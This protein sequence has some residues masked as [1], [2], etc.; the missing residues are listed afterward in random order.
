MTFSD[1]ETPLQIFSR[2]KESGTGRSF[3]LDDQIDKNVEP[4][5]I[6]VEVR[7][8]DPI[9]R[10][11]FLHVFSLFMHGTSIAVLT[12]VTHEFI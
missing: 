4:S 2:P 10:A 11:P 8:S 1:S 7:H 6:I 12:P 5:G 3:C 9:S